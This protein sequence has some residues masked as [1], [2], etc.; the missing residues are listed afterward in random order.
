MKTQ[1]VLYL[2]LA[3]SGS[4]FATEPMTSDALK[5]SAHNW[6]Y[7]TFPWILPNDKELPT[8]LVGWPPSRSELPEE[9]ARGLR[10][11]IMNVAQGFRFFKTNA[12]TAR[13]HRA[14]GEI[15]EPTAAGKELLNAPVS[16]STFSI[17]GV[18]P[19][20]QV[21]TYFPWGTNTIEESWIEVSM[22]AER[23]WLEMPYGFD[24]NP[25][26]PLPRSIP[27]GPPKFVP[28]PKSRTGHD[29]IL[30]W[31][32]VHY[33]LDGGP[34]R[35]L[36]LIQS[37]PFDARSE[38]DLYEFP[39]AQTLY[40][41]HTEVRIVDADGTAINGGCVNLHLDDN[42]LR[43]TDTFDFGRYGDDLRCWGEIEIRVDDKKYRVVVPSSLYKYIHGHTP[44]DEK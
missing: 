43:R 13:L 41:P 27:S 2:A 38:V 1:L 26:N 21:L 30:R 34:G 6:D 37:N 28:Y 20:A 33:H 3:F 15:V 32:S 8:F 16:I 19:S 35:E 25:A 42:H 7:I 10:L 39:K 11:D 14:N 12:I 22:G 23:Y 40:S 18:E 44:Q 24:R 31:E 17:P 4:S 9:V 5:I 36:S 29:H